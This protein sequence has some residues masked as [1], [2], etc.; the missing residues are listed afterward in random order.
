MNAA[1][2]CGGLPWLTIRVEHRSEYFAALRQA[3]LNDDYR[4]FARFIAESFPPG[5][6]L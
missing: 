5:S 4:P 2:L 6:L 1:L 3:Q